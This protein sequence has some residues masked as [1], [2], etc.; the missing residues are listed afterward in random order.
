[1]CSSVYWSLGGQHPGKIEERGDSLDSKAIGRKLAQLRGSRTQSEI[2]EAVGVAVST[3]SMYETGER[4]PNDDT[5]IALA[6]FYKKSVQ[7]IFFND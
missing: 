2:A 7:S 5:K 4:I 3:I 6:R 1:M